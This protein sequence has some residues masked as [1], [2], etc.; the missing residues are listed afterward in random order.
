MNDGPGQLK[1]RC[2]GPMAAYLNSRRVVTIGTLVE[3]LRLQRTILSGD[4]AVEPGLLGRHPGTQA[5]TPSP[6]AT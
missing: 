1:I 4:P 6:S 5:R 2:S 3:E